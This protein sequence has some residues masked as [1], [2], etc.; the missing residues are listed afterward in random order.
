MSKEHAIVYRV[1][2]SNPGAHLWTVVCTVAD[3]DPEGQRVSLAAW[4]PGSYLIRNYA[5]H[6]VR[7][8]ARRGHSKVAL[9]KL[10]K[11]TWRCA[12]C[13]GTLRIEYDVYANDLSVRGALL[14]M[15]RGFFNGVCLFLMVHGCT[16]SRCRVVIERPDGPRYAD[17]R[18]ATSMRTD[19]AAMWGFG[20]YVADNYDE[21]IDHPVEMG[22]LR[23]GGFEVAGVPHRLAISGR[24]HANIDRITADLEKLCTHHARF[25]GE[26]LP[27]DRYLFLVTTLAEPYGG[28]EHRASSSLMCRRGNLPGP[29]TPPEAKPYRRFLGL[30][31]H[32]YFHAWNIKRIKPAAFDPYDLSRE[33]HTRLMWVF[34]GITSY[35]D[36]LALVRSALITEESYLE[37]LGETITRVAQMPG[38]YKQSLADASFDAWTHHYQ[39]NEN[40]PNVCVS[41]YAKG[42]LAG[43]A[44]DLRLRSISGGEKSLDD[45]MRLLWQQYGLTGQGVPE[46]GFEQLASAVAG[47]DLGEFF[48]IVVRGTSELPLQRLLTTLGIALEYR[49]P[50]SSDDAGGST[51]APPLSTSLGIKICES[52]GRVV[53][54]HVY[55]DGTAQR[56]GLSA[57]DELLAIDGIRIAPQNLSELLNSY[58]PGDEAIC[59]F[60]RREKLMSVVATLQAPEKTIACLTIDPTAADDQVKQRAAWLSSTTTAAPS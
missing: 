33:T 46:N 18:V 16:E 17:W 45:V 42:A 37:L 54:T 30:C 47:E 24:R 31:S 52:N 36:D 38:R 8:A 12:P 29:H 41:Y 11:A 43:L 26:P 48:D 27:M 53:L 20:G 32:E 51:D 22:N 58:L 7:I 56:A 55:D 2:P 10:D 35:Y 28:L 59:A 19:S 1:T 14:D 9:E 57:R 39:P 5:R 40:T 44:L 50:T 3:P 4:I 25:F 13:K 15:T 60:F 23:T 6:V 21:L 34:E 49:A